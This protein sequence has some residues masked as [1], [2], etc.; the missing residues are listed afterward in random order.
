MDW[1]TLIELIGVI[2]WPL[3]VGVALFV[4]RKPLST[5]VAGLGQRVTK[6]SAFEVSIELAELP[7]PPSPWSDPNIPQSS[8]MTGG[9]VD[10]TTLMTLFDSIGTESPLE[11]LIVD[12]KDGEFW[13]ISRVFI[14]TVF[15]QA[16][17]GVKCVVFVESRDKNYRQF[18]GLT[19]TDAVRTALSSAYPW[20]ED[21]LSKAMIN[22]NTT[23]LNPSIPSGKAGEII[24]E[25]IEQ[26]EMRSN[27][28]PSPSDKWSKLGTQ[29]IWEHTEWLMSKKVNEYLRQIFYEWDSSQY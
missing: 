7:S 12:I 10:S 27:N 8:E 6:I 13:L 21:A 19:S 14:F 29:N 25:F 17:R 28:Q 9:D 16:M 3:V 1:K 5:F 22:Q 2:A 15:L 26:P 24:R 23:F 4:Y 20:L 11:Y 18:I